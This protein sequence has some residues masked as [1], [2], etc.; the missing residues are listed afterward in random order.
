MR[1]IARTLGMSA[2]TLAQIWPRLPYEAAEVAVLLGVS[3]QQVINLRKA[4]RERLARRMRA[5]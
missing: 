2:E 3:R 1:D 4:A 5:F